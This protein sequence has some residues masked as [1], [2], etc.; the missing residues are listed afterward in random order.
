MATVLTDIRY[1]VRILLRQP[2]FALVALLTLALGIGANI[3]IFSFVNAFLLRPL[4]YPEGDRLVRLRPATASFGVMSIAYPNYLDWQKRNQTFETIACYRYGD[5]NLTGVD[6][7]ERLEALQVSANLLPMLGA[8]PLLGRLFDPNDDRGQAPR[9]AILGHSL[10]Q[11]RFDGD[12][13]VVGQPLLLG[14]EPY[15]IVGVLPADFQFPPLRQDNVDLWLPVGLLERHDWFTRRGNHPGLSGIG[16]LKP[17]VTLAQGRA[18]M[19]RVAQQLEKDHPNENTGYTVRVRSY[20]EAVVRAIRPSILVLMTAVGC[21]LLIVC[22]NIAGLLLVRAAA[23]S[24]E[25]S[26]RCALGGGRWRIIQ[27]LLCENMILATLGSLAGIALAHCGI[28][29][30]TA[31]L[32]E[33]MGMSQSRPPLFDRNMLLFILGLTLGTGLLFGL[34]PALQSSLV[35]VSTALR[36]GTRTAT[37]GRRHH[38]LRDTLVV[39]EIAIAL[40]LLTGAGLLLRSFQHYLQADPGYNPDS[41]LTMQLSLPQKIYDTEAKKFAFYRDLLERVEPLPEVRHAGL[42]SNLLGSWQSSYCVDGAPLAEPGQTRHAEFCHVSP[43]YFE[44]LGLRLQTGRRFT[45]RDIADASPVAVVDESF[46]QRC[47]PNE[48]PL[49]KR[50]QFGTRPDPNGTWFNIVGVVSDVK[51]YGIDQISRESVYLSAFQNTFEYPN[52]VVR[53][54]D[55]PM[56][57]LG[58]IRQVIAQIDPDLAPSDIRTL[59][60]IVDEQSFIRRFVTTVLGIFAGTALLLS[61]LGIYGVT[62]YA[63]SQRTQEFGIRMALGACWTDILSLV[64]DRG[65]KLTLTGIAIG[66]VASLSLSWL[67]RGLLFGVTAWDPLTFVAVTFAL[68]LVVLLACLIPARRAAKVDPMEALRYE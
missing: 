29:L 27:Q 68:A 56:H 23:R 16:K 9:T 8:Q 14:G 45:E 41:T 51:P 52:L 53:T 32:G 46:V 4:P 47:W 31:V 58:P 22:V 55:D 43:A 35:N 30:L 38:R 63:V 1:G 18:D 36:G 64:L 7:P 20:H 33:N 6:Q 48:N 28:G 39:A 59:Q 54:Q 57:V 44:A 42:C 24:Q 5:L 19:E 65:G 10:W 21:V 34:F 66:V 25:F 61:A 11:R 67:I 15:S 17:G 26:V 12:P 60:A 37:A 13:E 62:A 3:T 49:G 40:V 50:L 2:L